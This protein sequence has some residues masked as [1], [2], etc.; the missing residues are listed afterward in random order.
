MYNFCEIWSCNLRVYTVKKNFFSQY[1]K[2]LHITSNISEYPGPII[3]NFTSLAGI[4]VGMII[5]IFVWWSP[6]GRCYDN[7]LNLVAVRICLQE[8]PLLITVAFD[9]SYD[10]RE[11]GFKRLNGNNPATL[12]TYLVNFCPII[13]EVYAVKRCNFCRDLAQI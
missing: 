13:S 6:K 1:C 7:Q 10:G 4:W 9:N 3:T 12:C 8:R 2:N 5:P 11:A